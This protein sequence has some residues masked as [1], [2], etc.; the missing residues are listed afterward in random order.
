M[1]H[2]CV[3][4]AD[5]HALFRAGLRSL[6]EGREDM[7]VIGEAGDCM[8]LLDLLKTKEPDMVVLDIS[9]PKMRGIEA[10]QKIKETCPDTKVLIVTMLKD[11]EYLQQALA[12]GADG[13]FLKKDA[14]EELFSAIQKIRTGRIYI[15]PHLIKEVGED[16][17]DITLTMRR[18]VLTRREQEVLKL[19]AEGKSSKE[20]ADILFLSVHT[21]TRHRANIM[22]KLNFNNTADLVKYA[23]E[24]NYV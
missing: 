15:S 1:N 12:E 4:L 7:E 21:V 11:I 20:I 17:T 16:W 8:E 5:D 19:V 23:I 24:K 9:M 13:Y 18:R 22:S 6:L 14:D 10:I 2:Y 3:V